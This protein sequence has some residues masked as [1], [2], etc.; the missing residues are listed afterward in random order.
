MRLR[1]KESSPLRNQLLSLSKNDNYKSIIIKCMR[2]HRVPANTENQLIHLNTHPE[3]TRSQRQYI[4]IRGL[5][6][7]DPQTTHLMKLSFAHELRLPKSIWMK[8]IAWSKV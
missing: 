4:R 7:L 6:L 3:D 1:R 5:L 8:W 2:K